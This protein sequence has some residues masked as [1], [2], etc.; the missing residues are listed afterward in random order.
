MRPRIDVTLENN[1]TA[2]TGKSRSGKSAFV[3]REVA[4][5]ARALF[6]DPDAEYVE[7]GISTPVYDRKTMFAIVDRENRGYRERGRFSYVAPVNTDEFNFW[8]LAALHWGNC[9]AVAE[10]TSDVTH[11]GKAPERWGQLVRRGAKRGIAIYA[12]TQF[13]GESDKTIWRNARRVV[14]FQLDGSDR[15]YMAKRLGI[16]AEKFPVQPHHYLLLD[17]AAPPENQLSFSKLTFRK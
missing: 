6:W 2:V 16:T 9:A 7:A 17:R 5:L 11:P 4:K 10:E 3:K 14:C 8:A 15:S 12:L 1:L 13:P